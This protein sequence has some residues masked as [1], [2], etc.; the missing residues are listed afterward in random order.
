MVDPSFWLTGGM[1]TSTK[2]SLFCFTCDAFA[3]PPVLRELQK[4]SIPTTRVCNQ[5]LPV[6]AAE[7]ELPIVPPGTDGPG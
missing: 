3:S 6:N 4:H 5:H 1:V 2:R 7:T